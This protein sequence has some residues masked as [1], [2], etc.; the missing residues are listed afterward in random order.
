MLGVGGVEPW[1]CF[2]LFISK[3][4]NLCFWI[5]SSGICHDQGII[6]QGF[7]LVFCS[8]IM[9]RTRALFL[10]FCVICLNLQPPSQYDRVTLENSSLF[11]QHFYLIF[12]RMKMEKREVKLEKNVFLRRGW[13]LRIYHFFIEVILHKTRENVHSSERNNC[14]IRKEAN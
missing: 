4:L 9:V 6:R 11:I 8:V 12:W 7:L 10:Y 1:L 13:Y 5:E 2:A 14:Q 3:K